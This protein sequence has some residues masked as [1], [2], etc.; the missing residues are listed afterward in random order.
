MALNAEMKRP[1]DFVARYGGEEFAAVLPNTDI[2]GALA[3]AEQMK[4]NIENLQIEHK[5]SEVSDHVTISLGVASVV[6]ERGSN[7]S[8]LIQQADKALYAAKEQGRNQVQF[9]SND[10]S[11]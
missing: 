5:Y 4:T 9:F 6:A 8:Q 3:I 2:S 1:C 7:Y 10:A 11:M